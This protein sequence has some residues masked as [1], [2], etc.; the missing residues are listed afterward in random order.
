MAAVAVLFLYSLHLAINRIIQVDEAQNLYM[1]KII[2]SGQTDVYFVNPAIFL[3]GPLAWIA[4]S[5]TS[6]KEAFLS[7]RLLFAG[8]FWF[9][10]FLMVKCT[11]ASLRTKEGLLVTFTAATLAPLWDY[12]FEIRH[13]N[14]LLTGL[15]LI[16]F[17]GRYR[18][19]ATSSY[20]AIGVLT[21]ILQFLA[22]KAFVYTLPI[23][24]YLSGLSSSG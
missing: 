3:L 24:A 22:F 21:A 23:S 8:V 17:L 2:G 15:L 18:G 7:S 11:G 20:F 12:G 6:A 14:L 10:I 13:D 1:A 19:Q 16:W 5:A 9:N 4:E